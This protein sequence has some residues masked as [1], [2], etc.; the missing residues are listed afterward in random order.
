MF[1]PFSIKIN[2][3]SGNCNNVN[4]PYAKT[5]L[6]DVIKNLNVKV[7]N[8]M[9]LTNETRHVE[10][11]KTC[12]CICRFDGI[13]CNNKQLGMKINVDVNSKNLL[14]K[15]YAIKDLFGIL[16]IVGLNVIKGVI[17]VNILIIQIISVEKKIS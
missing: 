12:K 13:I 9:S 3:C 14:I 8:L 6:P 2:K 4:D 10:W 16:V 15:K 17:L 11:H 1:Y 5:C 7:Y